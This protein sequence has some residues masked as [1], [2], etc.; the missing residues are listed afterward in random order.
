[1]TLILEV[2]FDVIDIKCMIVIVMVK[3]VIV[4]ERQ[5]IALLT[6]LFTHTPKVSK[7]LS[8]LSSQIESSLAPMPTETHVQKRKVF[9]M[10]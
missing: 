6:F 7:H 10:S 3:G 4:N 8:M 2:L 1:M 9:W 5:N